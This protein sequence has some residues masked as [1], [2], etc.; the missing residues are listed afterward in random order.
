MFFPLSSHAWF[1]SSVEED[2]ACLLVLQSS[3]SAV[4]ES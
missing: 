4:A 3:L 1:L 2:T